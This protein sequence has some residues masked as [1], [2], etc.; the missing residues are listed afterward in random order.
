MAGYILRGRCS[1]GEP[2]EIHLKSKGHETLYVQDTCQSYSSISTISVLQD[3]C[4]TPIKIIEHLRKEYFARFET[5]T[6]WNQIYPSNESHGFHIWNP[7]TYL[8]YISHNTLRRSQVWF[9]LNMNAYILVGVTMMTSSNR[10]FFHVTGHLCGE[11]TG[12]RWIPRTNAN[13]AALWC[14]L[15]SASE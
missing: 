5:E 2:S 12:P 7:I 8:R 15:W 13:D 11:F 1:T 6:D 9:W 10:N 3:T 14:F 4:L